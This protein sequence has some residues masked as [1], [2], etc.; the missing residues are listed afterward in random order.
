MCPRLTAEGLAVA[1]RHLDATG[2]DP[3][4]SWWR[5]EEAERIAGGVGGEGVEAW[6]A[7]MRETGCAWLGAPGDPRRRRFAP[8]KDDAVREVLEISYEPEFSVDACFVGRRQQSDAGSD[9]L[10]T[11][12]SFLRVSGRC[13]SE[14]GWQGLRAYVRFVL[15]RLCEGDVVLTEGTGG[16]G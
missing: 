10:L 13:K 12:S 7:W 6:Q 16:R 9:Q 14:A 4:A 1:R 11:I 2:I 8:E 3:D 15:S 5:A